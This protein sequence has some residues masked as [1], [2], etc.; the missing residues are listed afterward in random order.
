MHKISIRNLFII[1][2][3]RIFIFVSNAMLSMLNSISQI[4]NNNNTT[5]LSYYCASN[6][7]NNKICKFYINIIIIK[8]IVMF[9]VRK[10]VVCYP[11]KNY[12]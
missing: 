4:K 5:L 3:N 10:L 8:K 6:K 2:K 12:T 7:Y 11:S 9:P 1:I